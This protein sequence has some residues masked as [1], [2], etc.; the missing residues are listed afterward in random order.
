MRTEYNHYWGGPVYWAVVNSQPHREPIALQNLERQQFQ[1]YCPMIRRQRRR[2][3]LARE[4][5][6][7]LFPSYLFVRLNPERDCWRPLLSTYGVRT[8]VRCG[9]RPSLLDDGFIQSLKQREVDGVIM[10]PASTY[11]IG[12]QVRLAGGAVDGLVATIIEMDEKDRMTVLM[13]LL[14]R[15]VK[16]K[17]HADQISPF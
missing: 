10:R 12:Q 4:V 5:I 11:H 17:L 15:P 7:P 14:S 8:L 2:G 6:R 13:D 3:R 9:E 1:A 16:A